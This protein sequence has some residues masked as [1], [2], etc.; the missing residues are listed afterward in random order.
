MI[1]FTKLFLKNTR[2]YENTEIDLSSQGLVSITGHNGAGKS[3]IWGIFESVFWGSS[4]SGEAWE[5]FADIKKPSTE[6]HLDFLKNDTRFEIVLSRRSEKWKVRIFEDGKDI[7]PHSQVDAKRELKTILGLN[8]QEFQGSVHLTQ[9]NQ[10]ILIEGKPAERKQYI[11]EFFGLDNSYDTIW[12]NTKKELQKIRFEIQKIETDLAKTSVLHNEIIKLKNSVGDIAYLQ[13]QVNDKK[14]IVNE[15]ASDLFATENY[16]KQAEQKEQIQDALK[17]Y[18][19]PVRALEAKKEALT[20]LK[21]Y[22]NTFAHAEEHNRKAKA[23]NEEIEKVS[24][25]IEKIRQ[26]VQDFALL[27]SLESNQLS[28]RIQ[29]LKQSK[30]AFESNNLIKSQMGRYQNAQ[31]PDDAKIAEHTQKRSKSHAD[32]VVLNRKIFDLKDGNCPTCGKKTVAKSIESMKQEAECLASEINNLDAELQKLELEKESFIQLTEL[33]A[34]LKKDVYWDSAYEIELGSLESAQKYFVDYK[35]LKSFLDNSKVIEELTLPP[36]TIS[37]DIPA[38][39]NEIAWL[40]NAI[41][42]ISILSSE[43]NKSAN[44]YTDIASKLRFQKSIL[45]KEYEDALSLLNNSCS[46]EAN[47]TRLYSEISLFG[48]LIGKNSA[49]KKQ[50]NLL[51]AIEQAYGNNGLRLLRLRRVMKFVMARLPFYTSRLFTEKGLNFEANCET[52]SVEIVARRTVFDS[53]GEIIK[54]ITHDISALSG[55]EKKRLSV[56]LVLAL[57]D[58]VPDK[59]KSNILILDEIDANLDTEG[60]HLFGA[61]L[62]PSLKE[63]YESIFV[64]SHSEGLQQSAYYDQFWKVSK[65]NHNSVITVQKSNNQF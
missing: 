17:R 61:E 25:K 3:F 51:C 37:G 27:D 16:A 55:G 47:I 64:I 43:I 49:L 13:N 1:K 44:E 40:S 11:S 31:K 12:Q 50:E 23:N 41:T 30:Q 18:P 8:R 56:A 26:E 57:A 59:K 32:L 46:A 21:N 10:H 6:I 63:R 7:T 14:Y 53:N 20:L 35:I 42:K 29:K 19:E 34:K 58:C 28:E 54:S 15:I 22:A 65:T 45:H 60:Q 62:L 2:L 52:G 9:G 5:T 33:Q 36:P 4:P 48:D 39:E 38:L 24:K